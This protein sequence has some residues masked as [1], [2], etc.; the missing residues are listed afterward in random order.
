MTPFPHVNR[1]QA[2]GMDLETLAYYVR[3][4]REVIVDSWGV[5]RLK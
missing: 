2:R 4:A 5:L 3:E 1:R